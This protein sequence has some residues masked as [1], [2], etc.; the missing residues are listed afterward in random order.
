MASNKPDDRK[1]ELFTYVTVF[2]LFLPKV[3]S[4]FLL[5]LINK[6]F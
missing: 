5:D 1:W 2:L 4:Y 6:Y 3:S